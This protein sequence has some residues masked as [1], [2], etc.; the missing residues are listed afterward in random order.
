MPGDYSSS[1]AAYLDHFAETDRF[2]PQSSVDDLEESPRVHH[3]DV[4]NGE[5]TT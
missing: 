5:R 2:E 4:K 1:K 3:N